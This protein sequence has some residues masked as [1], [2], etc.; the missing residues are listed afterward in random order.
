MD[1]VRRIRHEQA[2]KAAEGVMGVLQETFGER[3]KTGYL[4]LSV[5][6]R[7]MRNE[8]ALTV[9]NIPGPPQT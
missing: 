8:V 7:E 2:L 6:L 3:P 9:H 4:S 1:N 5:D